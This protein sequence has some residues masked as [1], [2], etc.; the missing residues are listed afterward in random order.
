MRHYKVCFAFSPA[1]SLLLSWKPSYSSS[2][3]PSSQVVVAFQQQHHRGHHRSRHLSIM[4][5]SSHLENGGLT[6]GAGDTTARPPSSELEIEKKFPIPDAQTAKK[7]EQTL[8]SIGFEVSQKEEFV[9]WY[10]DLPAPQWHFSLNDCWFRYREK[11]IK[12]MK[13]WG[14]RGA[15]QVKRGKMEKNGEMGERDNDGMTVYE[16]LQGKD[17]KELILGMLADLSDV[18]V[19]D[20]TSEVDVDPPSS[21]FDS[22]YDGHD[23]PYLAGAEKLVPFAR[24]E[25][26]RTS[27]EANNDSEFSSLKVDVDKTGFGYMVGEV[28]AVLN[29]VSEDNVQVEAAKE[30]IRKLVD[31]ISSENENDEPMV[32]IGK[33]EYYLINNHRDHYDACVK[34]GVIN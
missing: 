20:T 9:D 5:A 33:L 24:L 32:A 10:F 15:W 19:L 4:H 34:S 28:E 12:V 8:A 25:T 22:N 3:A 1:T 6:N 14:W 16:E 17:A 29:N 18:E 31:L 30:Q 21:A 13:N 27:Y 11:K 26:F 2:Y 7:M 23:I